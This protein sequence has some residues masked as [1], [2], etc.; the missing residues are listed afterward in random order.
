MAVEE[1]NQG[2]TLW[3]V[4]L[5]RIQIIETEGFDW[6]EPVDSE[7]DSQD[8]NGELFNL[9]SWSELCTDAGILTNNRNAVLRF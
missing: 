4:V 3:T 9:Q 8:S 1:E 2:L 7:Y 6:G 5:N